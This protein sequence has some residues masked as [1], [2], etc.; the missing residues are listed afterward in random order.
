MSAFLLLN[1]SNQTLQSMYIWDINVIVC[2]DY[3][4]SFQNYFD[5]FK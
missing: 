5:D 4:F 2:A 3:H 1:I